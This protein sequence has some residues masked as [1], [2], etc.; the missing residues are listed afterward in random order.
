MNND[1]QKGPW[2]FLGLY[3]GI[4]ALGAWGFWVTVRDAEWF[5]LF[6]SF[7]WAPAGVAAWWLKCQIDHYLQRQH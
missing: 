6:V 1:Q 2:L 5:D 7:W 4:G 3:L